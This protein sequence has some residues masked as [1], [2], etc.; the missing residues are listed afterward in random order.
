MPHIE[1]NGRRI[2]YARRGAGEPLL[3]IHGMGGHHMSWGEWFLGPLARDY[4]LVAFDHRGIGGSSRADEPFTIADLAADAAGLLTALGWADVHVFGIAVGGMIAQE[5]VLRHPNLVRTLTIGASSSGGVTREAPATAQRMMDA[6]ATHNLDHSLRTTF[7]ANLS[8][9]FTADPANFDTY[10][11]VTVAEKAPVPVVQMQY[12]AGLAH[13][14]ASRLPAIAT[15]TLVLHGT[16]D[17]LLSPANGKRI[18]RLIPHARLELIHGAGHLFWWEQPQ[19]TIE[20][21][22]QHTQNGRA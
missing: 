12:R 18:A 17:A 3:L 9:R 14:A 6:I 11:R 4:D 10:R 5:L 16:A 20:L 22:R 19:R 7:E 8:A 1:V 15:P 21:L 13:D 2:F